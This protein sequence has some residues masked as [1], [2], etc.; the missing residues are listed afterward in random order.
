MMTACFVVHRFRP[1]LDFNAS[2]DADGEQN[3]LHASDIAALASVFARSMRSRP[4]PHGGD[5]GAM[6]Q[7]D[8]SVE[9]YRWLKDTKGWSDEEVR[10][11]GSKSRIA[12]IY[13]RVKDHM[14][15]AGMA[16]QVMATVETA[17]PGF[18]GEDSG[19]LRPAT[20]AGRRRRSRREDGEDE[21]DGVVGAACGG[22]ELRMNSTFEDQ[23]VSVCKDAGPDGLRAHELA[24]RFKHTAK[25]FGKKLELIIRF[26]HLYGIKQTKKQEGKTQVQWI[27]FTGV[28]TGTKTSK[29]DTNGGEKAAD[30]M[31][32]E[33]SALLKK[34][35][36]EYGYVVKMWV[37][38]LMRDWLGSSNPSTADSKYCKRLCDAMEKQ[39]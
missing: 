25:D 27:H 9:L 36:D 32:R 2:V 13:A 34:H 4:G 28:D 3:Y 33:R 29:G 5:R 23:I 11:P 8:L 14:V 17:S 37:P 6:F 31:Q 30:V 18:G 20:A 16:E 39:R 22:G 21:L 35:L 38:R 7:S 12:K 24:E 26:P 19:A 15:A 10:N 1:A